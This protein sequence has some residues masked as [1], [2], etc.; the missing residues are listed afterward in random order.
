VRIQVGDATAGETL[1]AVKLHLDRVASTD[2]F[3]VG[4]D[5]IADVSDRDD[6]FTGRWRRRPGPGSCR[7]CAA[8]ADVGRT[9][10]YDVAVRPIHPGCNCVCEPERAL[11]VT[12]R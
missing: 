10:D 7:E 5:I 3:R 6:R 8:A 9:E 11:C 12:S 1:A 2:P 4:N